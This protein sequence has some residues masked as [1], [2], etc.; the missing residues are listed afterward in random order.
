[1]NSVVSF[2]HRRASP[3]HF[4][5]AIPPVRPVS[6]VPHHA[7][8][9]QLIGKLK[10][11]SE[12]R[13]TSPRECTGNGKR[14]GHLLAG[15]RRQRWRMYSRT[16]WAPGRQLPKP[17]PSLNKNAM[18]QEHGSLAVA[19]QLR[20]SI[21][22]GCGVGRRI[23]GVRL[24]EATWRER[25]LNGRHRVDNRLPGEPAARRLYPEDGRRLTPPDGRR[26][27]PSDG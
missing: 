11:A 8:P 18:L 25:A 21:R 27:R 19:Y 2:G 13:S 1:M 15:Q 7:D 23:T 5:T 20:S 12:R 16:S 10:A 22:R 14:R 24:R 4:D 26:A 6:V 3:A 17:T 9:R